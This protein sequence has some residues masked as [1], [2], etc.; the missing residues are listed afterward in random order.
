MRYLTVI[1]FLTTLLFGDSKLLLTDKEQR[2]L[3]AHP[4]L[5]VANDSEWAPFDFYKDGKTMGYSMDYLRLL[6][7]MIGV[8]LQFVQ[9]KSWHDLEK[10]FE[11]KKLDIITAY[12]DI[13]ENHKYAFFTKPILQTFDGIFT[14]DTEEDL[15]GYQSL[16]GKK[17][18]VV[19]GYDYEAEVK[20]YPQ[21]KMV[22]VDTPYQ[23]F[24]LLSSG[25]VDAFLENVSV[26]NYLIKSNFLTNVKVSGVPNFPNFSVGDD[27]R[28][29]VRKDMPE[30]YAVLQKAMQNLS[31]EQ[32]NALKKKWFLN[33]SS[34]QEVRTI[35]SPDELTYVTQNPKIRI[36][37]EMDF[38]PINYNSNG[39]PLGYSIDYI[40]LV[41]AKVGLDV[42]FVS[43][44]TW[45][46][47]LKML[48]DGKL[49]VMM[50]IVK[51][52]EREKT[53]AFTPSYS[54]QIDAVFMK[55]DRAAQFKKLHDLDGKKLAVVKGF[56]EEAL[57]KEFY[58]EIELI[59]YEDTVA[60][61]KA[62]EFGKA[63]GAIN[64][65]QAGSYLVNKLGLSGVTAAFETNDPRFK[66][67]L[68]MAVKKGNDKLLTILDKGM[69]QIAEDELLALA[70]KW[71]FQNNLSVLLNL[72][73]K[74]RDYLLSKK[75]IKI[76]IDPDWMPYEGMDAN[77]KHQGIS[78][79]FLDLISKKTGLEMEL[80]PTNNWAES[81]EKA[82]AKKCDILPLLND[83]PERE[84]FLN[85]TS[86]VL[87][88]YYVLVGRSDEGFVA[89]LSDIADK[90]IG[91]VKGYAIEELIKKDYPNIHLIT[92]DNME[93][94]LRDVSAGKLDY[95]IE[96]LNSASLK[97]QRLGL[98]NLKIVGKTPYA[99]VNHIGV[100][101]DDPVLRNILDKALRSISPQE[102]DRIIQK[103]FSVKFEQGFDYSLLWKIL[104]VAAVLMMGVFYW[105]RKLSFY[106]KKLHEAKEKA[107]AATLE[108]SAFLANMSHE[109]RTPMNAIIGMT[110]LLRQTELNQSQKDYVKKI[111]NSSNALLGIINDILDFSKIEAGKLDIEMI[112]FDL[113]SV[114]ENV[115]TLVELK[116]Y[117][118]N[119]EFIV[120]YD[121]GMNTSLHGD[122]LRLAQ[123]LTNLANNAVKFTEQGEVGI[124]ITKL[125]NSMYRFEVRDTGIGLDEEQ[126]NRLFQ[127][128]SQA[129]VSTTR[130][131][132][133]TGLG[134]AISK[135]LVEMMNGTIWAE[136]EKEKGSSFIFEIRLEEQEGTVK[137]TL[138]FPD[139]NALIV[140]DTP[141]W[142][143]I[144]SRHLRAFNVN[145]DVVGSGEEA[146][147]KLSS[148]KKYDL[149]LMDWKMPKMDGVEA[150]RVIKQRFKELPPTIIMVSAYRQDSIVNAA[151]EQGVNVFLQKPINPSLLYDVITDVFGAGIKK[152][153]KQ[154]VDASSLKKQL[155]T[156]CGSKL[157]LVEDNA[158]NQEIIHGMLKGS[159]IEIDEAT[160]G[161]EAVDRYTENPG[162]YELI[163]MDLQMPVM[164]GYEA[165]KIIRAVDKNI[166]IIALT[167]NALASDIKKTQAYGM[168]EHLNKPIEVEKLFSALLRFI[169]KKCEVATD[170]HT[171]K[172]T[173]D[174]DIGGI[175]ELR[176][177][178]TQKGLARMVDDEAL[179]KKVTRDFVSLYANA[180]EKMQE[181]IK[182]DI[183]EAKR[184]AHTIK[185]LSANI[186]AEALSKSAKALEDNP[187]A[188]HIEPFKVELEKVVN[189]LKNA[190][191]LK[192]EN[193]EQNKEK[194]DKIKRD[195]LFEELEAAIK[196]RRPQLC[197]PVI[198]AIEGY[199]LDEADRELFE[200]VKAL[201]KKYKF[202]DALK[203]IEGEE[204]ERKSE[205]SGC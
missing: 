170:T 49:D 92:V 115:T 102:R 44:P 142:Q 128:F 33:G 114:I 168:N 72:S 17:V 143:M 116:A 148:G 197:Q 94:G 53:M 50:N 58:P 82:K 120:S 56:Y 107:E 191:F 34:E 156:L 7:D 101:N 147:E 43:G 126:K 26:G 85:F 171:Q 80:V 131:Y 175:T 74:E 14:R 172:D 105:N 47:F 144:L 103:W 4:V 189:E 145:V 106:N 164:D 40:K 132:G 2:F 71:F 186:G 169:A 70:K 98:A 118:K 154:S 9:D 91:T 28:I 110:Y 125:P 88:S 117:E 76:C 54:E 68:N 162:K 199:E 37:N 87:K 38:A 193:T 152:E 22:V 133:G 201:V 165:T 109:I 122:P 200:N 20:K 61:L 59:S 45:N 24:M 113:H 89:D 129:D 134:L 188:E 8:D 104:A 173:K 79:D 84:A 155:G 204:N 12:M 182:E 177:V 196:K 3:K 86:P 60:A 192:E 42:D 18:A 178:D 19:K 123:I 55:K 141:S 6:A 66:V 52:K 137:D 124:Y 77:G 16:F 195:M 51:T 108:K 29:A 160:N 13:P 130:K 57:L 127:S 93:E 15:K 62:V 203:I 95:F 183:D 78:A 73:D 119:L 150:T 5:K 97:I 146:L 69:K 48:Q 184:L 10:R 202:N 67:R 32:I 30:L 65:F 167:A 36:S 179:Y 139:K 181:L 64:S 96:T 83:T 35:L 140:D 27:I 149:V 21:I 153:Y 39:V 138:H 99:D 194:I 180:A 166:P 185:G 23:G 176:S 41:A 100:R 121:H 205:H 81:L 159:G 158:L 11:N 63:D 136:S 111:E 187:V 151:R 31:D 157:L 90:K 75:K 112:D 163:L 46:T 161:K 190:P 198:E 25:V 174:A 1:L 135:Q